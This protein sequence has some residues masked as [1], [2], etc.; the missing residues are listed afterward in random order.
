MSDLEIVTF[1][2]VNVCKILKHSQR[3]IRKRL[4]QT[5]EETN[6]LHILPAVYTGFQRHIYF[7]SISSFISLTQT[8][9]QQILNSFRK[10]NMKQNAF[11]VICTHMF[12]NVIKTEQ[13]A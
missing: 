9:P 11:I 5:S 10:V 13:E 8:M 12:P 7:M 1:Q 4:N 2:P 6:R 3:A